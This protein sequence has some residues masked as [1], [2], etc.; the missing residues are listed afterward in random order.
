[1]K[2]NLRFD[3]NRLAEVLQERELVDPNVLGE[4][5]DNAHSGGP[6]F[7]ECLV[8][9]GH[10]GDWD[11]AHVICEMFQLPFLPVEFADPDPEC[12]ADLNSSFL[13]EHALVPMCR[14]GQVLTVSMPGLVPADVLGMLAAESDLIVLPVV[15]TA[16][17]NR[18]WVQENLSS[19]RK[20]PSQSQSG[21]GNLFDDADAAVLEDLQKM[22]AD[23]GFA[24]ELD[25]VVVEPAV[26]D[27]DGGSGEDF[28]FEMV[29]EEEEL[30]Q[31][32]IDEPAA[33]IPSKKKE[34]RKAGGLELPPMPEF[35]SGKKR[36]GK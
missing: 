20:A 2:H 17:T 24:D 19:A 6:P 28:E 21:W 4:L 29:A 11:L 15:G 1:V 25:Q 31:L 33:P 7:A 14:F 30:G 27:A 9:E 12:L 5:L 34:S 26:D 22:A 35:E 13:F 8:A 16:T 10:I 3:N 18:R 23:A 32:E 36:A